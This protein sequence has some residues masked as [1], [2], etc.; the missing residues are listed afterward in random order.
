MV[1]AKSKPRP[2]IAMTRTALRGLFCAAALAMAAQAAHAEP[3]ED[4]DR[5]AVVIPGFIGAEPVDQPKMRY[6]RNALD[7]WSEGWVLLEFAVTPQGVPANIT[8]VD[9]IGPKDFVKVAVEGVGRW[10]YKPATRNGV[11]VEQSFYSI[12][13][14]F[15]F[16]DSRKAADHQEFVSKY[17]RARGHIRNDRPDEAI[18]ELE[19]AFRTRLNLYEA[20][21]GSFVLAVAYAHKADWERALYHAR[22]A[23]IDQGK[24]LE[25]AM[26]PHA[27]ALETEFNARTGNFREAVCGFERL[28][29]VDATLAAPDSQLGKMIAGI[30]AAMKGKE[31]IGIDARLAKHPLVDDAP[32]VW[33]H[34]LL[35][36]KFWFAEIKGEVKSYRLACV[37]TAHEAPIDPETLWNVPNKAGPC[38]L[39]VEGQP[40]ATFKLVE[41][42]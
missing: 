12:D 38:I 25:K 31:P 34:R 33:R 19:R 3:N 9:A 28:K 22:H 36:S 41:E 7:D 26:V 35:R 2:G 11:P 39:R 21:M 1:A 37:G 32:A 29:K 24:Y 14:Q 20:A 4:C 40:G 30:D 6:P 15:L 13:V 18:A 10:R 8:V 42:W 17:K 23:N 5:P 16:T 27:L